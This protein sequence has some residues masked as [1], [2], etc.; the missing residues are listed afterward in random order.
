MAPSIAANA[1]AVIR[2]RAP[3]SPALLSRTNGPSEPN[4]TSTQSPLLPLPLPPALLLD[5]RHINAT[6]ATRPVCH[7]SVPGAKSRAA[8]RMS[9][10]EAGKL[11]AATRFRSHASL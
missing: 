11:N 9:A 5:F 1:P 6:L 2:S 8:C 10:L 7:W 3:S 4:A